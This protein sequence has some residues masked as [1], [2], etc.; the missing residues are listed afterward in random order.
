MKKYIIKEQ[1]FIGSP[2]RIIGYFDSLEKAEDAKNKIGETH[3]I[4]SIEG[5]ELNKEIVK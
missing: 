1:L 4:L 5:I 3:K 2:I